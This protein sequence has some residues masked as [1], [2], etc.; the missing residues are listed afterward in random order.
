MYTVKTMKCY[1]TYSFIQ[2]L[3]QIYLG[4][5]VRKQTNNR[6]LLVIYYR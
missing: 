3:Y 1:F 2:F 6:T 4:Y 5:I